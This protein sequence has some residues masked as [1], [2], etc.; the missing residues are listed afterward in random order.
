MISSGFSY[1]RAAKVS[2]RQALRSIQSVAADRTPLQTYQGQV[3]DHDAD[4]ASLEQRVREQFGEL[5]VLIAPVR[6]G[7]RRDLRWLGGRIEI[8]RREPVQ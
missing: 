6:P 2:L 7:P 1:S 4:A 5:P 8:E 3:V